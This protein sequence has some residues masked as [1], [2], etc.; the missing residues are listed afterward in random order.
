MN[1]AESDQSFSHPLFW[2]LNLP[3]LCIR[4]ILLHSIPAAYRVRIGQ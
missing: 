1:F 4:N 2:L 3:W